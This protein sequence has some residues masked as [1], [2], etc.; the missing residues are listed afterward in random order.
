MRCRSDYR[1]FSSILVAATL[2]VGCIAQPQP[3]PDATSQGEQVGR[4]AKRLLIVDCLLPGQLRS[5]GRSMTF[6]TPRRP[7]KTSATECEI[8]GGEYVAFDRANFSTALGIWLPKASAGDP[9]AQTYVGEIFEK[10]LGQ[11]SDPMAAAEWYRKAADQGYQ[12]AQINLGY[13]YESGLGVER[14]L[15]TAMNYY[16]AAAGLEESN[17]EHVTSVE[18]AAR[19]VRQQQ[20]ID[21]DNEIAALQAA[22]ATLRAQKSK[23]DAQ[24]STI[25]QLETRIS[26][27]HKQINDLLAKSATQPA[28]PTD[29][30]SSESVANLIAEISRLSEQLASSERDNDSLVAQLSSQQEKTSTLRKDHALSNA[31]LREARIELQAQQQ[32]I[33]TIEAQIQQNQ[34]TEEEKLRLTEEL[35]LVRQDASNMQS[36]IDTLL[37]RQS[38]SDRELTSRLEAAEE[39]E[40]KLKSDLHSAK[41]KLAKLSLTIDQKESMYLQKLTELSELE[42]ETA[43]DLVNKQQ[44][45]TELKKRVSELN[46]MDVVNRSA[47]DAANQQIVDLESEV[48]SQRE[49]LIENASFKKQANIAALELS[50]LEEQL[51]FQKALSGSQQSRIEELEIDLATKSAAIP[52]QKSAQQIATTVA[53]GPIIEVIEPPVTVMRGAFAVPMPSRSKSVELIGRVSPAQN[54]IS[55]KVNGARNEINDNGIF[56]YLANLNDSDKVSISAVDDFGARTELSLSLVGGA[57]IDTTTNTTGNSASNAGRSV[58]AASDLTGIQFGKYHALIIGNR[59][60]ENFGNLRTS[61][62]DV[63]DLEQVLRKKYGFS[64]ELLQNA[65]QYE[66]LAALNRKRDELTE[67]DNLLI[68]FAGHGQLAEGKGYWL[69]V[70]S[71]PDSTDN[72]ISSRSITDLV[73]SMSAKHVMVVADSCYSGTL[74]RSSVPRLRKSLPAE[75][76]IQWYETVVNSKVR[77]VLS[78]GGVRPVIDGLP[79]S[80]NSIFAD[81]LIKQLESGRGVIEAYSIYTSVQQQVQAAAGSI[82]MEQN[83]LYSPIKFA[84]H[85][86]GEFLFVSNEG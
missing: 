58:I 51:A 21:R 20:A 48:E 11:I 27:K 63:L 53:S 75:E 1:I 15:V 38:A 49:L 59:D 77:T 10:G 36:T 40:D 84:G 57:A 37:E 7:I 13:L 66:I 16:R 30:G 85:E 24:Q 56:T 72:W 31:K 39:A 6:L 61:L 78:S 18:V 12:R 54:I 69:P 68:Y 47:I 80:R 35:A 62:N 23:Y 52:V 60:Y 65:T 46:A 26:S 33:T 55:L 8:R 3:E 64:T 34:N 22:N 45:I 17:L 41:E 14:N 79:D 73:D 5:L 28:S 76:K 67:N 83:P 86:S 71:K 50:Q 32:Q 9:E 82:G 2:L 81:A 44:E 42:S 70:D 25:R 4:D 43:S 29:D 19:K 74:S